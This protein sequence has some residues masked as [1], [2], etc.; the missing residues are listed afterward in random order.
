MISNY[1]EFC[2]TKMSQVRKILDS[3]MGELK[4]IVTCDEDDDD[5]HEDILLAAGSEKKTDNNNIVTET[6]KVSK[7]LRLLFLDIC[8]R[9]IQ[10]S[11]DEDIVRIL[12][13]AYLA[14]KHTC[15]EEFIKAIVSSA[16]VHATL[17]HLERARVNLYT[18]YALNMFAYL[19]EE[20][21]SVCQ[22]YVNLLH[23]FS[24]ACACGKKIK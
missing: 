3:L 24:G 7:Q 1:D 9:A 6:F 21:K 17:P 2:F 13:H 12:R 14:Q 16:C 4:T 18:K 5:I 8:S 15:D 20:N 11:T 23:N 19:D 22:M 10:D